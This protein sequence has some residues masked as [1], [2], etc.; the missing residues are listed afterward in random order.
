MIIKEADFQS[1]KTE[2]FMLRE[3]REELEAAR[4]SLAILTY[5]KSVCVSAHP[6]AVVS[7]FPF[8]PYFQALTFFHPATKAWTL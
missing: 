3:T 1:G 4:A 7:S 2:L 6:Q 5:R 8:P